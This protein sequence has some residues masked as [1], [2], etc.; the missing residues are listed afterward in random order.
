M[1]DSSV[2]SAPKDGITAHCNRHTMASGM[3]LNGAHLR[4]LRA[5][6]GHAELATTQKYIP[7]VVDGLERAMAGRSYG[8]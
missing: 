1:L 5:A 8:K 3:L 4:D 7:L 6:L 2:K